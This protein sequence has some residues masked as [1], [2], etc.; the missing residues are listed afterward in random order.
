MKKNVTQRKFICPK[1]NTI[2]VAYKKSCKR[3]KAGHI[4]TMYCW[5]CKSVQNL[6]Q[7]NNYEC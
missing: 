1:C 4:K 3:T 6:I 5:R 2:H 7:L